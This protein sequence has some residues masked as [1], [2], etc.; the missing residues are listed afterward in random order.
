MK[1]ILFLLVIVFILSMSGCNKDKELY[2]ATTTSLD[3]SGLLEYLLPHFEE[4]YEIQVNVIAVGTGAALE[5][6]KVGEV[7][8]LLVHDI[9]RE[10]QFVNDG[11]GTKRE[12]I[13]YNDFVILGPEVLEAETL[14]DA[15]LE[16]RE[17]HNFY[18]RGDNSGTHS[19]E[20]FLWES[21]GLDP[22]TFGDWYNETG[23]GMGDTISMASFSGYYTLSDRGTYLSMKDNIDISIAA[24]NFPKLLNQYGVI[25]VNPELYNTT[26]EYADL[27]YDWIISNEAQDLVDAYRIYD[28]QLF[29]ANAE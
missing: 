1:R 13:M 15:L 20:L 19:K 4:K 21:V 7:E 25:K 16:I 24:E 3:N 14:D 11:Y 10:I 22:T 29:Y 18:S 27:F 9:N 23:Q 5:L 6:G 17:S 2:I 12:N 28:E 26:D 8:I